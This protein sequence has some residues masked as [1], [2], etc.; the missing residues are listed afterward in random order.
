M[1]K[2]LKTRLIVACVALTGGLSLLSARLV[3]VQAVDHEMYAEEARKRYVHKETLEASRGR[4]LDRNGE[5]LA[6]NQT[7]YTLTVDC[8]RLNAPISAYRALAVK[9]S[10]RTG[11]R[12][13]TGD[14]KRRYDRDVLRAS[15]EEKD[16]ALRND[17]F[18]RI[19]ELLWEPLRIPKHELAAKLKSKKTGEIV[20]AKAIEEDFSR[21]LR[22][23]IRENRLGGIELRK[24]ER[25]FYPSP[26]SLT[27]VIGFVDANGEGKAGVEKVFQEEMTGTPGF[28]YTE[29]DI[30]RKEIHAFRGEEKLPVHGNNVRLTIDMSL[31]V[32]VEDKLD[33]AVEQYTPEKITAIWMDP[34]TGEVLAMASRPHFNLD[35]REGIRRNLAITDTYQP[36]STF[37]IVAFGAAFDKRLITPTTP[38]FCHWGKY[39]DEG[40]TLLDHHPYG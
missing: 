7:V 38:I 10:E 9:E 15:D 36:G 23:I 3:F 12:I 17:Y 2:A 4:I 26:K 13:D 33:Q 14:I 34:R 19:N 28:R 39:E 1:D 27:H 32:M 5:L 35:T 22:G 40:F 20:L 11:R 21:E 8:N 24:T 18:A 31:Q 16:G 30:T 29:R 6:R 37:K 25:R